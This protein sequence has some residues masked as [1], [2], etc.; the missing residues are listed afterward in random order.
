MA[1]LSVESLWLS[2]RASEPEFEGLRFD[3]FFLF[4]FFIFPTLMTRLLPLRRT[5]KV[6]RG[7]WLFKPGESLSNTNK[8]MG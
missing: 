4:L 8:P 7:L 5:N 3:S 6:Y 1:W 2:G